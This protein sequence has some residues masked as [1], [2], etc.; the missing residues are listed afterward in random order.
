VSSNRYFDWHGQPGYFRDVTRHFPREARLLDVG[1]GTAWLADHFAN[2]SGIDASPAAVERATA[3]GRNVRQG[4]VDAP[5]PFPDATFDAVVA[6]DLLE[7]VADPVSV[8]LEV[9]RVLRPRGRVFASSPDA[10]RWVWDDY[11]HRRPFTRKA[12]RL[13]FADQGLDVERVGYES[14]APG[15]GIISG[16]N[17]RRRRPPVFGALARLRL[18]RRNVWLVAQ[19]PP[20]GSAAPVRQPVGAS[21]RSVG[22]PSEDR[23]APEQGGPDQRAD[24]GV[25]EQTGQ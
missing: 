8:V 14:V 10:Q 9:R 25:S 11:T 7:H 4:D 18:V 1:C 5:L 21:G 22:K 2:Y 20:D 13:L 19:R 3:Q 15:T 17:P 12:F 24:D 23:Q 6:K 16:L